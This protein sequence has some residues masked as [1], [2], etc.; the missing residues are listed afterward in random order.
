MFITFEGIEGCGKTT[1]SRLLAHKLKQRGWEIFYS[2]EPGGCDL[3]DEL[4]KI[5]LSS[6]MTKLSEKSELFLYLAARSQHVRE[7]ILPALEKNKVVIVDRFNDSTIAYQGYGRGMDINFIIK[8]CDFAC[9]G[10]WPDLT[11]VLDLPVIEGLKRAR[12]RNKKKLTYGIDEQRFEMEKVGFHESVRKGYLQL[13]D[14]FSERMVIIDGRGEIDEVFER[15]MKI[16][17]EK[18]KL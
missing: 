1:Q 13:C 10:R 17:D 14:Q 15:V 16:V 7:K 9:N 6:S 4:R 5:L 18:F 12:I 8:L 3:G 11:I 2:R